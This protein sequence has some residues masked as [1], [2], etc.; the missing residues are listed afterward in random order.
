MKQLFLKIRPIFIWTNFIVI[1]GYLNLFSATRSVSGIILDSETNAAIPFTVVK[2]LELDLTLTADGSGKFDIPNI[3]YGNYT[4]IIKHIGYKESISSILIDN[5]TNKLLAFYLIPKNIEL[6]PVIISDYKSYS[7]FDDLNELSNVLKGKNLERQ[8]SLTLA[9]TLKNEAGLAI[10]S[11]GPA[12]SRPVIRGLGSSRVLISED[13][14]KTTD[15]S[16]TSPDHAVTI[17]PFTVSRVEVL[18]GPKILTQTPT[19]IGGIVNVV[20][21][22]IPTAIHDNITGQFGFFGETVNKGYLGSAMV[23]IPI[24]KIALKVEISHRNTN[25]LNTPVGKL[26]NSNSEN[27]NYSLASSYVHQNGFVGASFRSFELD[28]G[29]PGGFVGAHPNGVDISINKHQINFKSKFEFDSNNFES[30]N[31][32]FGRVYYRHKEFEY[33]GAIGSEFKVVNYLGKI[34]LNHNLIGFLEKG[35]F[36]TSF[37]YRDFDIGGFVFTTPSKSLNISAFLFENYSYK[38]INFEFGARYDFDQITPNK[39]K[40]DANI[41]F[42][43]ERSFSNYSLSLSLLYQ[44]S[45]HVFFGGNISKSS[46]VPTIEELYSEGP[47]LAAYSYEV[48]NP[49]LISESGFGGEIFIYH[50]FENLYFNLTAFGNDIDNYIIPRNSGEINYA[51]FLPIYKTVGLGAL[52]YGFESRIDWGFCECFEFSNTIS[53]TKGEFKDGGNLPQIPPIKGLTEIKYR[54]DNLNFGI[55]GD[56]ALKQDKLDEFEEPTN[57]YFVVNIFAQ[58]SLIY[59]KTT[60]NFSLNIDNIF[61][62]EYRNHLSR[63]KSILPEAGRNFRLSYKLYFH[64]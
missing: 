34:T 29:V 12:P 36:G 56:W 64:L 54:S 31:L 58:Y 41:G 26:I 15:L 39:E 57:G 63:V 2:I 46:R 35:I 45:E 18:R 38:K 30:L 44:Q 9:S 59:T 14:I 3:N 24:Q 6:D 51:T 62:T 49:N 25:D 13:G 60:S 43:R 22:E 21:D 53:F 52:L 40:P 55:S 11:M 47:H 16:A 7:K 48:G 23:E 10:R 50:Q 37:E 4:V 33:S 20:R 61:N 17:D 5:S 32:D 19:S 28:Y 1:F 8:L 27:L 42:I